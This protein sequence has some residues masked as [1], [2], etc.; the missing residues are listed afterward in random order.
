MKRMGTEA[1]LSPS[2]DDEARK[3][4]HKIYPD[5]LRSVE[6]TRPDQV[7]A[8]DVTYIPIKRAASSIWLSC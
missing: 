1:A 2:L 5:L 3:P 8:M 6:I 4:G 7:W